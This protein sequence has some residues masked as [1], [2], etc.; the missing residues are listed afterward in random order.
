MQDEITRHLSNLIGRLIY[1]ERVQA[2]RGMSVPRSHEIAAL[3]WVL[4]L[5]A[6]EYPDRMQRAEE[7]AEER[8]QRNRR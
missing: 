3:D 5:L 4:E 1:L 6:D 7:L 8:E 2:E